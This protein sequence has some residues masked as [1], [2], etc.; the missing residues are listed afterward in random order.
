MSQCP[1]CGHEFGE[2]CMR[3]YERHARTESRRAGLVAWLD[4]PA[5]QRFDGVGLVGTALL[6]H[7]P[8]RSWFDGDEY[9]GER[10]SRTGPDVVGA[11]QKCTCDQCSESRV[12]N[13]NGPPLNERREDVAR[14]DLTLKRAL[15]GQDGDD[16]GITPAR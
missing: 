1:E 3:C 13:G 8:W 7:R 12:A 4:R 5:P 15:A 11:A 16:T 9:L 6:A 10:S 2:C 14:L